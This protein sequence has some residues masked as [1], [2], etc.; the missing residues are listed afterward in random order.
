MPLDDL[1]Q[2]LLM[3]FD[4]RW[5]GLDQRFEPQRCSIGIMSRMIF[6][7]RKLSH[8]KAEEVEPVCFALRMQGMGDSSFT[9]VQR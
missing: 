5:A 3:T 8:G 4:A 7:C 6:S 9:G 2:F 1:F